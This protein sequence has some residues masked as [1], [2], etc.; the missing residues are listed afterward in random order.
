M[1]EI[2]SKQMNGSTL[3][4]AGIFAVLRRI[5]GPQRL[6]HH[7]LREA[8]DRVQRCP[9]FMARVGKEIGFA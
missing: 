2:R 5:Q 1:S 6:M 9:E 7:H 3:N 8:N 4:V